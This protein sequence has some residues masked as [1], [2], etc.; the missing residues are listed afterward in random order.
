MIESIVA[1]IHESMEQ[2]VSGGNDSG[3]KI[4]NCNRKA[5][6]MARRVPAQNGPK[7]CRPN[8]SI[9]MRKS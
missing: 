1:H 9:L 6:R 8:R 3:A 4:G 2:S 7:P 5:G